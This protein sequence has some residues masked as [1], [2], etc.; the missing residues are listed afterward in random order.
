MLFTTALLVWDTWCKYLITD[1][2]FKRVHAEV[3]LEA[4]EDR[5]QSVI[6]QRAF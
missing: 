3:G 4:G 5:L 2:A 6:V 1:D